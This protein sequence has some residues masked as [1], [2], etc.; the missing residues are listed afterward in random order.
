MRMFRGTRVWIAALMT[1]AMPLASIMPALAQVQ[2]PAQAPAQAAKA[3]RIL[4]GKILSEEGKPIA[5]ATVRVRNLD[6]GQEFTSTPASADGSYKLTKLSPGKYEI[7]VQTEKGVFLGNRTI[8]LLNK[9]AQTY[10]FSLKSTTPQEA[11]KQAE[12]ARGEERDKKRAAGRPPINPSDTAKNTFWSNP[13]TAILAG[14]AIAVGTAVVIDN[15]RGDND[16]AS[17]STP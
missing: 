12:E 6:T 16:N 17:P 14:V 9:Q 3:D 8:D 11:M 5:N 10:S 7:S 2:V 1:A 15:L 4:E 13:Y